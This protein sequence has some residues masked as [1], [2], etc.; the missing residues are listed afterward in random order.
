MLIIE[1]GN[2]GGH[3]G[4]DAWAQDRQP[5]TVAVEYRNLWVAAQWVALPPSAS[6]TSAATRPQLRGFDGGWE[7]IKWIR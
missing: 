4:I 3:R 5:A 6:V 7:D 1:H 2:V